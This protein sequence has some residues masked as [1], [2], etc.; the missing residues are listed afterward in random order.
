M[1]SSC[2][3]NPEEISRNIGI[4]C[5]VVEQRRIILGKAD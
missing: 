2:L 3:T 1:S 4:R 5:Q